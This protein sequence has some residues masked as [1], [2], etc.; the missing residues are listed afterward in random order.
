MT[1]HHA[2][3]SAVL[4]GARPAE[5]PATLARSRGILPWIVD[6]GEPLVQAGQGVLTVHRAPAA[7]GG[8]PLPRAQCGPV[9]SALGRRALCGPGPAVGV[10]GRPAAHSRQARHATGVAGHLP[11]PALGIVGDAGQARL[12]GSA[13]KASRPAPEALHQRLPSTTHSQAV[14]GEVGHRTLVAGAG[15]RNELHARGRPWKKR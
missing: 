12:P 15:S 9:R 8:G 4:S 5:G 6:L 13:R 2:G 3:L 14:P 1:K 7:T 11:R 10:R